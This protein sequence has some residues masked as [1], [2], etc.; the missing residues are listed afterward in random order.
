MSI[1]NRKE[2][3]SRPLLH[4]LKLRF[5]NIKYNRDPI[6]IVIPDNALMGI[7][8]VTIHHSI[9]LA[10][11]FGRMI[12]VCE[13]LDLLLLHLHVLL[14]LLGC[15]DEPTVGNQVLVGFGGGHFGVRERSAFVGWARFWVRGAIGG[16]VRGG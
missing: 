4:L 5:N 1:I 15:H 2:R 10:G 8:T 12:G 11:E 3:A 13:S 16:G 9:L 7:S 6:L 14:L